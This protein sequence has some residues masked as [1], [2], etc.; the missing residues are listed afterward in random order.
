MAKFIPLFG[1]R[2]GLRLQAQAYN[3]FNHPQYNGVGGLQFDALGVQN[4]LGAGIFNSTRYPFP[5]IELDKV[6]RD[7]VP[8]APPEAV[9]AWQS[10]RQKKLAELDAAIKKLETDKAGADAIK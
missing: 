2:K 9:S 3:L 7:L 4:S 1:E 10:E 6:P 8:L 5:G